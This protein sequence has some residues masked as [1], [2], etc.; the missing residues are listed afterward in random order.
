MSKYVILKKNDREKKPKKVRNRILTLVG[1]LF[2]VASVACTAAFV[3]LAVSEANQA[4]EA[5]AYTQPENSDG[6]TIVVFR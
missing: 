6:E 1:A 4:Q 5:E 2:V 3:P